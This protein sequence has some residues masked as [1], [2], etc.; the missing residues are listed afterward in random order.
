MGS[1]AVDSLIVVSRGWRVPMSMRRATEW[2]KGQAVEGLHLGE[3]SSAVSGPDGAEQVGYG[4]V[5]DVTSAAWQSATLQVGVGPDGASGSQMWVD[6]VVVW[7]DPAPARDEVTGERLRVAVAG[8]C[9][10]TDR[11]VVGVTATAGTPAGRMLPDGTPTVGLVCRWSGLN[12]ASPLHLVTERRLDGTAA[13]RLAAQVAAVPL[14]HVNGAIMHCP[15]DDGSAVLVA[16][17]YPGHGD[18]NLWMTTTGCTRLT[19]GSITASNLTPDLL[20]P[21]QLTPDQLPLAHG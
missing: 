7:L 9:P 1:P 18:A 11:G 8:N 17:T 19:N 5:G 4:F 2:V 16:L 10:A 6:A 15:M 14:G 13:A 21:D 3:G 12:G 20:T